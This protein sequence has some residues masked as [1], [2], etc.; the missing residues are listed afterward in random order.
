MAAQKK[1]K[2]QKQNPTE[3]MESM[4]ISDD[5][6]DTDHESIKIIRRREF[7]VKEKEIKE[8]GNVKKEALS[9]IEK[10][11]MNLKLD[12]VDHFEI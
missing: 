6:A 11:I 8:N 4:V 3:P 9:V 1:E 12:S 5:E 2:L 7:D 10:K